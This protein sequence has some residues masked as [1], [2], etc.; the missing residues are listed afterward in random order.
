MA[1]EPSSCAAPLP[2]G[3]LIMVLTGLAFSS[4]IAIAM[5]RPISSALG[6]SYPA[7]SDRVALG[8]IHA[9]RRAARLARAC[10]C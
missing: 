4:L 8:V 10:P 5:R 9:G 3:L 2:A 6:L 7:I 1:F